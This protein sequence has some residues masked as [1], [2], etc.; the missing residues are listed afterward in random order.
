MFGSD[1]AA[2]HLIR[3]MSSVLYVSDAP[4]LTGALRKT[5]HCAVQ[6]SHRSHSGQGKSGHSLH[7]LLKTVHGDRLLLDYL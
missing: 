2:E 5:G 7:R 1:C 4:V 6:S 3:E